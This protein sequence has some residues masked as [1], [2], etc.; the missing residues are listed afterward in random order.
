MSDGTR[1]LSLLPFLERN[2]GT[3][4]LLFPLA[5]QDPEALAHSSF[6]FLLI[7]DSD[8]T[9]R[10][11]AARVDTDGG[12]RVVSLFF[13]VQKDR[14]RLGKETLHP[15]TNVEV[16]KAW[17]HAGAAYRGVG[18]R[19]APRFF[20]GQLDA[21]GRLSPF[22]PLFFCKEKGRYFH[23]PC[24]RCGRPLALCA[25]DAVLAA[26]GLPLYSGS[27][28]RYLFCEACT[29][30]AG[31]N[32][33]AIEVGSGAPSILRDRI[34]LVRDF[35]KVGGGSSG[36]TGFPCPACPEREECFGSSLK[37]LAR[38]VPF[39]FYPFHAFAFDAMSLCA[40]DFLSLLSGAGAETLAKR[41]ESGGERGR[42]A[43]VRAAGDASPLLF[44]RGERRF[45]EILYLKLSLLGELFDSLPSGERLA[46]PP[47]F[48]PSLDRAWVAL[49]AA[50]NLLPRYWNFHATVLDIGRY[51]EED[52]SRP[53]VPGR[54][55]LS[56]LG[57][58]WFEALLVNAKQN[59][60]AVRG[61]LSERLL[62]PAQGGASPFPGARDP[63]S[64]FFAGNLFFEPAVEPLSDGSA[65]LW[66][67]ALAAGWSILLAGAGKETATARETITAEIRTVR[68]R[69]RD[70]LFEGATPAALPESG[71][72]AR[73]AEPVAAGDDADAAIA[74]ILD[75]ILRKWSA[76]AAA[77]EAKPPPQTQASPPRSR[78]APP[79]EDDFLVKTVVLGAHPGPARP[80]GAPLIAAD[81]AMEKTMILR[82]GYVAP[83]PPRPA[84]P[85]PAPPPAADDFLDRTVILGPGKSGVVPPAPEKPKAAKEPEPPPAAEPEAEFDLEKTVILKAPPDTGK[86]RRHGR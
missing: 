7:S 59:G 33:Y 20:G 8:P 66:D 50:R 32:F 82:A 10:V 22:A 11:V 46:G 69:V 16:E 38:I 80:T 72:Q 77:A 52:A 9:A 42:A 85:P 61:A 27:L 39:S 83:A 67:G 70:R 41:L 68:A 55:D 35:G 45:L 40:P 65:E 21:N 81:P 64:P 49:G 23:P 34:S 31:G 6:P 53:G 63:G 76:D 73:K 54:D 57:V 4:H 15:V 24:P 12:D 84:V 2:P 56:F 30:S 26:A 17:Q 5:S 78:P 71:T 14:Y 75:A 18:D 13:L 62:H 44:E 19:C 79:A 1:G 37:A 60:V 74:G 43:L 28:D 47:E 25:D 51:A 29:G 86:I 3:F 58:A 36:E 48:R